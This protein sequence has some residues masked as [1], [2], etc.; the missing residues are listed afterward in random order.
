[1]RLL[2]EQ[3]SCSLRESSAT[4]VDG[5]REHV[6]VSPSAGVTCRRYG[7][8]VGK[9]RREKPERGE[10]FSLEMR[11]GK[12]GSLTSLEN[13]A[14]ESIRSPPRD[15]SSLVPKLFGNVR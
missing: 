9:R 5:G 12:F 7:E 13:L 15:T 6:Y 3:R 1:M 8:R 4:E 10:R 2:S 14:A 11:E